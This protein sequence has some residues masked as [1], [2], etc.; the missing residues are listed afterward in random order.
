MLPVTRPCQQRRRETGPRSGIAE[1]GLV[2]GI[3]RWS[4]P[5]RRFPPIKGFCSLPALGE[6]TA[7]VARLKRTVFT[8]ARVLPG[9]PEPRFI[10][11]VTDLAAPPSPVALASLGHGHRFCET[12]RF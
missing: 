12:R 10:Q 1:F 11:S 5:Q 3:C 2:W 8:A 7:G 9:S 4:K 6:R